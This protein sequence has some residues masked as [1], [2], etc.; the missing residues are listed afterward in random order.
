LA[1]LSSYN[2]ELNAEILKVKFG[3]LIFHF[4]EPQS[5]L[6]PEPSTQALEEL[7]RILQEKMAAEEEEKKKIQRQQQQ[8]RAE[9][10]QQQ[11][12]EQQKR[13]KERDPEAARKQKQQYVEQQQQ[14][15]HEQQKR[16][17]E[18]EREAALKQKQEYVEQQQRQ[19]HE[20][21]QR[22]RQRQQAEEQQQGIF[23][24]LFSLYVI[25]RKPLLVTALVHSRT[26][27]ITRVIT[28]DQSTTLLIDL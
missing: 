23:C 2:S 20:Q 10:E 21:Q 15:R 3:N 19:R 13:V 14:K 4:S 27:N 11:R 1:L 7:E 17:K 9:Q 28:K 26:D 18:R 24:F 6:A 16:E 8:Q 5:I 25:L 12:Q 22:E